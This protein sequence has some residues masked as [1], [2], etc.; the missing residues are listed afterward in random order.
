VS[1]EPSLVRQALDHLLATHPH[2]DLCSIKWQIEWER[3]PDTGTEHAVHSGPWVLVQLGQPS[4]TFDKTP[5]WAI[6]F[7][8]IFKQTGALHTMYAGGGAVSDEPIWTPKQGTLCLCC[9]ERYG[10]DDCPNIDDGEHSAEFA[11]A[12]ATLLQRQGIEHPEPE[13]VRRAVAL[14]KAPLP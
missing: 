10:E 4:Q 11:Y 9:G 2:L 5:V 13:D 6:Y 7:F 14:L 1:F 8:A 3:D 12:V